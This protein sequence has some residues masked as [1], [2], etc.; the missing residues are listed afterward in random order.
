MRFVTLLVSQLQ[1]DGTS[2]SLTGGWS[3][4]KKFGEAAPDMPDD[5]DESLA[6]LPTNTCG[7]FITA[8]EDEFMGSLLGCRSVKLVF[9]PFGFQQ[10]VLFVRW[11]NH[12]Q[13]LHSPL[14]TTCLTCLTTRCMK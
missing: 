8:L 14:W 9:Q 10:F 3:T 5:D 13:N 11:P 12:V 7:A 4:G 1:K 2:S 6:L